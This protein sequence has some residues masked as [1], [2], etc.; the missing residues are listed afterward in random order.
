M[1]NI[2]GKRKYFDGKYDDWITRSI[3]YVVAIMIRKRQ[4]RHREVI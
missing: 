4:Y 1:K 2:T 3:D